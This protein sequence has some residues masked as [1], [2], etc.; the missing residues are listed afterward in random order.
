LDLEQLVALDS[1]LV[2]QVVWTIYTNWQCEETVVR[3]HPKLSDF[4]FGV[5]WRVVLGQLAGVA[6]A[7]PRRGNRP[8]SQEP[9]VE[10]L[11][12]D[13]I[14][15]FEVTMASKIAPRTTEFKKNDGN[16]AVRFNT[17]VQ[18]LSSNKRR[19]YQQPVCNINPGHPNSTPLGPIYTYSR[20]TIIDLALPSCEPEKQR[21][22]QTHR[23]EP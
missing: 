2:S 1:S 5:L 20:I 7:M 10:K 12:H 17:E 16:M 8:T 3:I 6:W 15:H 4:L 9:V 19:H 22:C 11:E 21:K 18:E 23:M 13:A 14:R